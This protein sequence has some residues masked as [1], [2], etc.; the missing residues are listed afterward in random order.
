MRLKPSKCEFHPTETEYLGCIVSQEGI[1]V[2]SV[3][4]KAI[5][6]WRIVTKKKK[7]QSFLG[8]C[9]FYRRFMEGFSKIAKPLYRLTEKDHKLNFGTEQHKAF[10]ELIC[11]LTHTP[12]FAYYD[13]KKQ[14]Q[15]RQMHPNMSQPESSPRPETTES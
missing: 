7:I 12:I 10:E 14:S 13:P 4:I 3:K 9:N 5:Q 1:K 2:D 11:K 8:F 15:L 6:T